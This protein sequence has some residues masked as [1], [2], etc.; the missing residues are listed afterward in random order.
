MSQTIPTSPSINLQGD[1]PAYLL[2]IG[3]SWT[4]AL[5][6]QRFDTANPFTGKAWASVP[7]ADER[8][9]D[10]AVQAAQAAMDGEWGRTTGFER[11]RLMRALADTLERDADE[12][13]VLESTDNGKLIRETSAQMRSHPE[14]LRY[15]AG[16]A[17]KLE[18]EVIPPQNPDFLIYTR[19]EPI[20]VV[21]AI[22]PWN[23]PLSLLMWKLAPALAA[24]CAIVVKPS[25]YTPV[26]ALAL[27][28]RVQEAGFPDGVIN[29]LTGRSGG[30]G[31]ALVAH[32]GVRQVAFTGSPEVGIKVAQGAAAHLA[33]TTLE[34]GGKSAQVVFPD[35]DLEACV[36]GVMAGIFA[37][38]GQ[39]CVAGSRLLV[40]ED[41]HDEL[42][43]RLSRRAE[44]ILLG[45]PLDVASEMGPLANE[46][47]L[48]IVS[49]F[50]DRARAEGATVACGGR[51]GPNGGLFY[52][53]T[54]LTDMAWDAEVAQEEVFGPVLAVLRFRDEEEALRIANSTKFG[55][56]AGVWTSDV[57]RAHR[58]AHA[59]RA[60][61][62]WVNSYRMV[63]PN[64]P[65]GGS[66][67]S[68]WGRESGIESVKEYTDTKAIWVDLVGR[69]RDP[70]R[71]GI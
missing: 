16:I 10:L 42:V 63:A 60:G 65:F 26:T 3:G 31:A 49:G 62:V 24:G 14:W 17:D 19:H 28:E 12:L 39:T 23:S 29:V 18:G 33:R 34:L 2:Y 37:A 9:V 15:F 68:G 66:G 48:E 51:G 69:T 21:A 22:V 7:D 70:F 52:L 56:A 13:A 43:E 30:L 53:P 71:L 45:D 57:R 32:P 59:L 11:A 5:S 47:Q 55:L 36:N 4:E 64:V 41:V 40:H 1:L 44:E 27:A 6:G 8:D 38:S 50:V 61:N 46:A 58:V 25:L 54:I 20:G 35:A 67:H